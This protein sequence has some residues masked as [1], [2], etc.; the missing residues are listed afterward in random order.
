ML[1][2]KTSLINLAYSNQI[3]YFTLDFTMMLLEYD[4]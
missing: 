2:K 1:N 4:F 3:K